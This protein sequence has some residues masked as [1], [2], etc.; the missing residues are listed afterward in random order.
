MHERYM[1]PTRAYADL[2][3]GNSGALEECV[4]RTLI[5]LRHPLAPASADR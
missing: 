2:I 5:A 4:E 1:E 3:V